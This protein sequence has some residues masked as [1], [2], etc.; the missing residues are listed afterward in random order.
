M[1]NTIYIEEKIRTFD[2]T[3]KILSKF[4]NSRHIYIKQYSEIFNIKNQN[5]RIQKSNPS[6]ILAFKHN[7][8]VLNTPEGFGIGSKKNYYFS[9]MYN[10]IYDCRYCFLQGMYS[11][12]NYVLFVNYENFLEKI[13]KIIEENKNEE[14]TFFSG[15]DCD[16]IALEKITGFV[17]YIL[18]KIICKK[19]SLFEFRTKSTQLEPFLKHQPYDNIIIAFSLLPEELASKLDHRTPSIAKRII[20]IKKLSL[21]GWKIGLRFDPLIYHENWEK[22]YEKLFQQIFLNIDVRNIHS[23]SFGSLRFPKKMFKKINKMYPQ[24]KLFSY[25][26]EIRQNY[27]SFNERLEKEMID[28]CKSIVEK[29]SKN[30]PVFSCTPF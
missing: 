1:V 13:Y 17:S 11:S 21:S 22:N 30:I 20:S 5:F 14:L 16:S 28:F 3:K 25:D 2:R 15:Y 12:S 9:H 18:P 19:N 8:Y 6:L 27:L 23:I 4:K 10:C 7:N 24:E 29:N 26:F